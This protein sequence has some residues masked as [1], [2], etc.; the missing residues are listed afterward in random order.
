MRT[1]GDR[2]CKLLTHEPDPAYSPVFSGKYKLKFLELVGN[3]L[4][5]SC[6]F[7]FF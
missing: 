7:F 5:G 6:F 4:K 2:V 1:I 3:I